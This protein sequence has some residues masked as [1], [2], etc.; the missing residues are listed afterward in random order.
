MYDKINLM[1]PTYQRTD[2]AIALV[3]SAL[4]TAD[5]PGHVVWTF[6]V[7]A[8]DFDTISELDKR[9]WPYILEQTRQPNLSQYF[10]LLYQQTPHQGEDTLVSMLGDDMRFE[11]KGWDTKILSTVNARDGAAVVYCND[12]FIAHSRWENDG[13]GCAVNLFTTRKLVDAAGM[14][15]FMCSYFH[16]EMIDVVWT[17]IGKYT[18]TACYLPKVTIK[19]NHAS[20]FS[21]EEQDDTFHRLQPVRDLANRT[22]GNQQYARAYATLAAANIIDAGLGRWNVL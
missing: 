17:L 16:A 20:A 1:V 8:S 22:P 6:C 12:G 9:K 7:N 10:N 18:G 21:V 14:D 2:D 15:E 13:V 11:T 4:A 3:E 5:M 19:H